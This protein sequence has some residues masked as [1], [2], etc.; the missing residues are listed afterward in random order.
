VAIFP[1][2]TLTQTLHLGAVTTPKINN[3]AVVT[4]K[5]ADG[6]VTTNKLDDGAVTG[7]KISTAGAAA[8]QVLGFNGTNVLWTTPSGGSLSGTAGGDLSGTYPDPLVNKIRGVAVSSATPASGQVLKF[9]GAQWAPAAEA[10][11]Q[12][13]ALPYS[14][15]GSAAT[16]LLSVTNTNAGPALDGI[17]TAVTDNSSAVTGRITATNPGAFS[18]GV[19][20]VNQGSGTTGIGVYGTHAGKGWGVYGS[21]AAGTGVFGSA[22]NGIGLIGTS[23]NGTGL[24]ADSKNGNA[25]FI[26]I[27]NPQNTS[28]ALLITNAGQGSAISVNSGISNAIFATSVYAPAISANSDNANGIEGSTSGTDAVGMRG[29]NTGNG[30]GAWGVALGTGAGVKASSFTNGGTALEAELDGV[31]TGNI[32]V[33]KKNGTNMARIDHS[34]RGYFNNGTTNSGADVAEAFRVEGA[35]QVYEPGD[36]LVISQSTDRTV[37][38]SATPYS[39]LVAGVYAT[40]PGLLLTERNAVEDSLDDLVPMGVIGVIPTKVCMEGGAIKRGD[41]LVT[42]SIAGVAMKADPE[43]VKVGQVLGKALQDYSNSGIGKIKVLVSVK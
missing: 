30:N 37:E 9:D 16:S 21:S 4:P 28:D 17:N 35:Q 38:R 43:K 36:V 33:F 11:S 10:T 29:V 42:S 23:V 24:Y 25:A 20:G 40:K 2:I 22:A 13:F 32:A 3:G 5:L 26:E 1:G 34:G 19:K 6:A 7:S 31:S 18:A 8:G 41:L 27:T 14:G 12:A 15:S 39:T